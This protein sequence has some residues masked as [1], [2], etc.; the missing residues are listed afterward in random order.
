MLIKKLFEEIKKLNHRMFFFV[1]WAKKHK[2]SV[3]SL[4]ALYYYS[5]FQWMKK[6]NETEAIAVKC[7]IKK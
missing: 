7:A 1:I 6:C 2:Q 3:T 4:T 5:E